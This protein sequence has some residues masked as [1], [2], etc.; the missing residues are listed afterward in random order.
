MTEVGNYIVSAADHKFFKNFCQLMY[1]YH[2][3]KEFVNSEVIF[4][5]LGLHENQADAIKN[6]SLS[7]LKNV[8]YR[9][10][11][12]NPYPEFIKPGYMTWSWKPII[13]DLVL[14]ETKGNVFWMDSANQIL[15]DLSPLWSEITTHGSYIPIAGTGHLSEFTMK[16]TL[17]YIGVSPQK[18]NS[19]NRAGNTCAF[20]YQNQEVL[21][22]VKDWK[23]LCLIKA[24]VL[25]EGANR[26]NHR[27]DQS[28]LSALLVSREQLYH[29]RMTTDEVDISSG[30]PIPF[31][32]VRNRFPKFITLRPG[33]F[34]FHYFNI[35]RI[36]DILINK[37]KGN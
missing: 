36:F 34:A 2:R 6:K 3:A 31:I 30:K 21:S 33:A 32:S 17:D 24:C 9:V 7:F 28:I 19:R 11:D 10:F 16:E 37:I 14:N 15:K 27:G 8:E 18:Y 22:L 4:Y 1:S 13:I 29:L 5:D 23:E 20:S 25:P 26:S 12:F 35:L